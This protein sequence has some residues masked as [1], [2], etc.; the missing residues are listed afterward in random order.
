MPTIS[1]SV[2]INADI[3]TVFDLISRVEEFPLYASML[4]EVREIGHH[5]YRWVARVRGLTLSWDSVITQF[6]HPTRLTWRSIRGFKNSGRYRLSNI[7]EG[8]RV[9]LTIEYNFQGGLLDSLM[10]TLAIPLARTAAA[11][12]LAK[13]KARLE[14][15]HTIHLAKEHTRRRRRLLHAF[16]NKP[17]PRPRA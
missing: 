10:E 11:S 3:E 6:R 17:D 4:K 15:A 1:Q 7:P 5:T 16:T 12:I 13:V 14:P 2:I 8:T 9:E